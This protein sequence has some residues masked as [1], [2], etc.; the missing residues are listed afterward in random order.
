MLAAERIFLS[1]LFLERSIPV[2][3]LE[4]F[5]KEGRK[6]KALAPYL[7]YF[8]PEQ[9]TQLRASL[10]E[11]LPLNSVAVA[12]FLYTPVGEALLNRVQQVVR[13]KSG[14]GSFFALRSAFILAAKDPEGLNGP[15][16]FAQFPQCW[17]PSRCQYC[18]GV[19]ESS[20]NSSQNH[21]CHR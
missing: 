2:S 14:Q 5:A 21:Q 10:Q 8:N 9:Q 12:Q 11:R 17:R 3:D 18:P 6:S 7:G 1:F 15:Q 13:T 4:S 16:R 20:A 19:T